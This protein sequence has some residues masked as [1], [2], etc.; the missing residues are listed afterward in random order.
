MDIKLRNDLIEKY[1]AS[2][3]SRYNYDVIKTDKK[4][5]K[6][7]TKELVDELR[8]FFLDNLYSSPKERE[9]LDA[10]FK[11]LETYV[12][13]PTKVW[14]LLGSLTTAI[15]RFGLHFPAAIRTG[16]ASLETHTAARHFE[17]MLMQAAQE[18]EYKVPLTDEQFN[19]CLKAIPRE[20]LEKFIAQLADLFMAISDTDMLM[21]TISLL[22]DVLDIMK[23]KKNTYGPEDTD[24]IQLGVDILQKGHHL[25]AGLDEEVRHQI[26]EYITYSEMKFIDSV[27]GT[28][29][30]FKK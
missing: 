28:K 25:L 10:A 15:F 30:K 3:A 8:D 1:R 12:A 17:D 13:H 4:F 26:V 16:M 29:K 23:S 7:F 18:R 5:P 6:R 14:G 9:K 21:K 19:E 20:H 24:A 22:K 11:Q 27:T 2:I